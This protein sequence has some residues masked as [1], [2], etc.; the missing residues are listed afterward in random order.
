MLFDFHSGVLL[1]EWKRITAQ[2]S[3]VGY[4]VPQL[5]YGRREVGMVIYIN[6]FHVYKHLHVYIFYVRTLQLIYVYADIML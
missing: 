6:L 1:G 5:G 2:R 4:I 3:C